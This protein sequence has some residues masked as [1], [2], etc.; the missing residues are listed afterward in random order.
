MLLD[1]DNKVEQDSDE[2]SS[3]DQRWTDEIVKV[4]R[5]FC[6]DQRNTSLVAVQPPQQRQHGN[7]SIDGT[8]CFDRAGREVVVVVTRTLI[9]VILEERVRVEEGQRKR[10]DQ[11]RDTQPRDPGAFVGKPHLGFHFALRDHLF[12]FADARGGRA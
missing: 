3:A 12:G 2:E 10:A 5:V 7:T 8:K 6:L 11:D 4:A 9:V 1:S